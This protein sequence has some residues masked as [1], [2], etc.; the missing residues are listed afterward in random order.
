[1]NTTNETKKF[2]CTFFSNDG[3]IYNFCL[4]PKESSR[5][6]H[7]AAF[8]VAIFLSISTILLNSVTVLV[9][10]KSSQLRN[11]VTHFMIMV[12]S[13]PDFV[14]GAV[15]LPL[16]TIILAKKAFLNQG[17]CAMCV[18]F[19]FCGYLPFTM[20]LSTLLTMSIE[21]YCGVIHP[22][23]HR[24]K[25]TK[26]KLLLIITTIWIEWLLVFC[27]V[28]VDYKIELI[29]FD[30]QSITTVLI[31]AFIHT[32][33]FYTSATFA[34]KWRNKVNPC[35]VHDA[36]PSENNTHLAMKTVLKSLRDAKSYLFVFVAFL[37]CLTPSALINFMQESLD[38]EPNS[39]P[40]SWSPLIVLTNSSVNSVIFFWRNA[41]LRKEAW[42]IF[43]KIITN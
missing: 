13:L 4:P 11:K 25:V 5:V 32:K 36:I 3:Q 33:I 16:Y 8:A 15:V 40:F 10:I 41:K 26:K 2:R 24:T 38:L 39:L 17:S 21:R 18:A 7:T 43:N 6:G 28:L 23:F 31:I 42:R 14:V 22:L 34:M 1:M 35:N 9:Y 12:M 29:L 37:V 30:I 19:L 27:L 20:S